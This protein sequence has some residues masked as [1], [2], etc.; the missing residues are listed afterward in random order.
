VEALELGGEVLRAKKK[1][2]TPVAK[3]INEKGAGK[4][5][6]RK[7]MKMEIMPK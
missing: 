2:Q 7:Q 5:A 6:G 4:E 1:K 3:N